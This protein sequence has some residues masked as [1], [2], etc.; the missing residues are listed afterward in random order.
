MKFARSTCCDQVDCGCVWAFPYL[1]KL[2]DS[3]S[4]HIFGRNHF[5][6]DKV[7]IL[8]YLQDLNPQL[9]ATCYLTPPTKTNIIS[10]SGQHQCIGF[11]KRDWNAR[12][13]QRVKGDCVCVYLSR[14]VRVLAW[15]ML[16][17]QRAGFLPASACLCPYTSMTTA[18]SV[19]YSMKSS[20]TD[21]ATSYRT[22]KRLVLYQQ[23]ITDQSPTTFYKKKILTTTYSMCFFNT[24]TIKPKRTECM[25]AFN[26]TCR[27]LSP[28]Q[29]SPCSCQTPPC[30]VGPWCWATRT[31][32]LLQEPQ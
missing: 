28:T 14:S 2:E 22:K 7:S 15:I 1:P 11:I 16:R 13:M 18:P 24:I 8:I 9:Q 4:P 30:S 26:L 12:E 19:R 10:T 17:S 20:V 3:P 27:P 31:M 6:W 23:L 21:T 29:A 5:H 32:G 25:K